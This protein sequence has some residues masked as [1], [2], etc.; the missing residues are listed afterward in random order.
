MFSCRSHYE[1]ESLE[2]SFNAF[3]IKKIEAVLVLEK[4]F[5]AFFILKIE[6]VLVSLPLTNGVELNNSHTTTMDKI[7]VFTLSGMKLLLPK[8]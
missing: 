7:Q 6:A 2:M 5:N 1:P 3:F 4:S 8:N